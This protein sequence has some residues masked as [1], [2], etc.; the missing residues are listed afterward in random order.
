MEERTMQA[1]NHELTPYEAINTAINGLG[2]DPAN[3][4]TALATAAKQ[5]KTIDEIDKAVNGCLAYGRMA[6][7]STAVI[8]A[9]VTQNKSE[10]DIVALGK[11]YGFSRA[12]M[13]NYRQAGA[14]LISGDYNKKEALPAAMSKFLPRA[15]GKKAEA[16]EIVR[17]L[18]DM[19]PTDTANVWRGALYSV[20]ISKGDTAVSAVIFV[21][22]TDVMPVAGKKYAIRTEHV[23][24]AVVNFMTGH[25]E[26]GDERVYTYRVITGF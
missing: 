12:S 23:S 7:A 1:K 22:H 26:N 15:V 16:L 14:R 25:D 5:L 4:V 3:A 2:A 24:R 11:R 6:W 9:T 21:R 20:T 8:I 10:K 18:A 19:T 13:Y 17:H